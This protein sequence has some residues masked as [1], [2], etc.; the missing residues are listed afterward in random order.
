[1]D[2]A[3]LAAA[4]G[5]VGASCWLVSAAYGAMVVKA[6][7]GEGV[8]QALLLRHEQGMPWRYWRAFGSFLPLFLR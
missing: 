4:V 5:T 1:M 2:T 8:A 7:M 3:S 6:F